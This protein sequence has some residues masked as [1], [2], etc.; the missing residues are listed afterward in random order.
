MHTANKDRN[1]HSKAR[2]AEKMVNKITKKFFEKAVEDM[3]EN[4]AKIHF[5]KLDTGYIG[6]IELK[7]D[8]PAYEYD[9]AA[10]GRCYRFGVMLSKRFPFYLGKLNSR[11]NKRLREKIKQGKSY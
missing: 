1:H 10:G 8:N 3:I 5:P 7:P 11:N 2:T 6:I 9:I 4:G